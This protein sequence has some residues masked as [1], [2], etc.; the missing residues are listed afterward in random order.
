[1]A[2]GHLRRRCGR[3][4]TRPSKD[5][6][7]TVWRWIVPDRLLSQSVQLVGVAG[8]ARMARG[9][10]GPAGRSPLLAR[11]G[12]P[13]ADYVNAVAPGGRTIGEIGST[14]ARNA[15]AFQIPRL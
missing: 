10:G 3:L 8:H 1:M 14:S 13:R 12:G 7:R 6:A 4:T 9:V 11:P 5:L 2:G 15:P